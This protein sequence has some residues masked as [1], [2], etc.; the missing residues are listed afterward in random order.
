MYKVDVNSQI[1]DGPF[2]IRIANSQTVLEY[3][4]IIA[5]KLG[6]NTKQIVLALNVHKDE[7]RLLEDNDAKIDDENLI[8]Y[9]KIFVAV[10]NPA[11]PE[12]Q[13]KLKYLASRLDHLISL[14][15]ALPN[16]DSGELNLFWAS[17]F[18]LSERKELKTIFE[19]FVGLTTKGQNFERPNYFI[20]PKNS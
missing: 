6:L 11:D 10:N 8:Q 16:M 7:T 17:L 4:S 9:S 3:K 14:Y 5:R 18:I 15:F 12:F 19:R 2:P 13:C 1:V 20:W